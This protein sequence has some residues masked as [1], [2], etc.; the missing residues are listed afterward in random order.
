MSFNSEIMSNLVL[1][2]RNGRVQNIYNFVDKHTQDYPGAVF[3]EVDEEMNL[4]IYLQSELAKK[5]A[6]HFIQT[7]KRLEKTKL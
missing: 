2:T 7:Q 6:D 4:G 3:S 5:L 1:A